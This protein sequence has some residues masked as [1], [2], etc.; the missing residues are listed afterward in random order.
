MR[1]T[2]VAMASKTSAT[3]SASVRCRVCVFMYRSDPRLSAETTLMRRAGERN[4]YFSRPQLPRP[5]LLMWDSDQ[6]Q[7]RAYV[8]TR[9]PG[10]A[11]CE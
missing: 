2:T 5:P 7:H 3:I 1:A 4:A 6:E 9:M 10:R 11:A 8:Q